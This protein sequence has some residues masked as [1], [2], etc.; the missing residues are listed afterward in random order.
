M[1]HLFWA[2]TSM[3]IRKCG[4][5]LKSYRKY[6]QKKGFLG[7]FFTFRSFLHCSLLYSAALHGLI[8]QPHFLGTHLATC[9]E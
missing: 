3:L 2:G 1:D 8:L 9:S 6:I 7:C 4:F 5:L